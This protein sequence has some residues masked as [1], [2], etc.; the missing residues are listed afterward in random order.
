[1]AKLRISG[2]IN[3]ESYIQSGAPPIAAKND[4]VSFDHR[5]D[6]DIL[7]LRLI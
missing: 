2:A 6:K 5:S 4:I 3:R 1:L 7:G